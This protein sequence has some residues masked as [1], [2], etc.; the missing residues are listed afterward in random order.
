MVI[1]HGLWHNSGKRALNLFCS[2]KQCPRQAHARN[3]LQRF[4]LAW[5][6][7]I[8][9]VSLNIHGLAQILVEKVRP[10]FIATCFNVAPFSPK[11]AA[12]CAGAC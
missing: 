8:E 6:S 11:C 5:N 12:E 2:A 10:L 9:Q 3:R 4:P 7:A 1:S